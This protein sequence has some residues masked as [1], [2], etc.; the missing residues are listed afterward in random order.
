MATYL[1]QPF[2]GSQ[3]AS[4]VPLDL[5]MRVGATK[6]SRTDQ[7]RGE[8]QGYIDRLGNSQFYNDNDRQYVDQRLGEMVNNINSLSGDN[9]TDE[10]TYNQIMNSV[11][12]VNNDPQVYQRIIANR[13]AGL[14]LKKL[15]D[16]KD[17]HPDQYGVNN[18]KVFMKD[19][20]AWR[21]SGGGKSFTSTYKPF[22][23]STKEYNDIIDDVLKNPTTFNKVLSDGTS[24]PYG[25]EEIKQV[26]PEKVQAAL[27]SRLSG[28]AL[29]QMQIDYQA[30]LDSHDLTS[31]LSEIDGHIH[32]FEAQKKDFIKQRDAGPT[33]STQWY[34]AQKAIDQAD[35][36][37]SQ[38]KNTY[39]AVHDAGDPALYHTFEKYAYD[40]LYNIG[41]S[42]AYTQEG[43]IEYN[44]FALEKYKNELSQQLEQYK[45]SLKLYDG[46]NYG[47]GMGK[48]NKMV[49][50][51]N[52]PSVNPMEETIK[53]VAIDGKAHV[54]TDQMLPLLGVSGK[55]NDDGSFAL[56]NH[57]KEMLID[58]APTL[59]GMGMQVDNNKAVALPAVMRLYTEWTKTPEGQTKNTS[60]AYGAGAGPS[61]IVETKDPKSFDE[62]VKWANDKQDKSDL[63][64]RIGGLFF[65]GSKDS[66]KQTYAEMIKN[67]YGID[68]NSDVD[69]N[70]AKKIAANPELM[71]NMGRMTTALQKNM[72]AGKL[73]AVPASGDNLVRG[74][75]GN[76]Y[77]KM[78]IQAP[79]DAFL[80]AFDEGHWYSANT[81]FNK[82]EEAGIIHK[83]ANL[84]KD[85]NAVYQIPVYVKTDADINQAN[86]KFLSREETKSK[87]MDK[88]PMYQQHMN[89]VMGDLSSIKK[90]VNDPSGT[91]EQA[92]QKLG[93]FV[94]NGMTQDD[95]NA[96]KG[97]LQGL[98]TKLQDPSLSYD[99]KIQ[100][101]SSLAKVINATDINDLKTQLG[102]K[103]ATPHLTL[104]EIQQAYYKPYTRDYVI[105]NVDRIASAIAG[106]EGASYTT[107][108]PQTHALGKYQF[109]HSTLKSIYTRD[110]TDT[111][112]SFAKFIE[113][114]K[115]TPNLQENV[116]RRWILDKADSV[117]YNPLKIATAHFLGDT[118]A[119]NPAGVHWESN[120]TANK[121]IQ[122]MT[123]AGYLSSFISN[124]GQL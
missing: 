88:L 44:P 6:Q 59:Q 64:K 108:N 85:G 32:D 70:T 47:M 24:A 54:D 68:I 1:S 51:F 96:A 37:I 45:N 115:S 67:K 93:S 10:K 27:Q 113:T 99:E 49:G 50:G 79:K 57:D 31:T 109:L 107:E 101:Y 7:R 53:K 17:N 33:N 87:Y 12:G 116:M 86:D 48:G 16:I 3:Y 71:S 26:L 84:D 94:G 102:G 28:R 56:P 77:A 100:A 124:Y 39:A 34:N 83:A 119:K 13:Q 78:Y 65:P 2:Q 42:Y 30:G 9:L 18:E 41:K 91:V 60:I 55:T 90:Y 105:Q 120:P 66:P 121:G 97:L 103:P 38:L 52:L 8:I 104:P 11:S 81:G 29:S 15:Q 63:H 20:D 89:N 4:G 117:G 22:Y 21:S 92:T 40:K 106:P 46:L 82:L 112:P 25:T 72:L 23:D 123:P 95:F 61:S 43:K 5:V 74:S 76:M 69:M 62:F 114:F 14:Q 122:N 35:T 111:Y 19:F 75:E 98:K 36:N 118:A 80:H 110:Y 58:V 73:N